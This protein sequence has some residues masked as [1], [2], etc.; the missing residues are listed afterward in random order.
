MIKLLAGAVTAALIAT[1]AF[2]VIAGDPAYTLTGYFIS[3]EGVVPGNDVVVD[4]AIVGKVTSVSLASPDSSSEGG[5]RIVM[6]IDKGAPLHQGT[7]AIIRPGGLLGN[8]FVQ[9]NPGP[10]GNS[11]IASGGTLP[12]Q[13]TSAPVDLDQVM[14]LFDRQTREQIR[15][16]TREGG[17]ALQDRGADLNA[18]LAALP[19]IT[20][21]TAAVTGK[22]AERDHELSALDVEFD[23]IAAMMAE[24]D[25]A[26]RRDL[27]NGAQI[28][29]TMAAHQA[30]LRDE[31]TYA[32]ATLAALEGGL[33]GHEHDL[34]QT[35][36]QMPALLRTLTSLSNH[37]ASALA[38]VGP[39][40]DDIRQLSAE[41]ASATSYR[42]ASGRMLLRVHPYLGSNAVSPA[43]SCAGGSR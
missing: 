35:L 9:L 27:G 16:L 6:R 30:Q 5:A 4:G 34:N 18:L 36:Q 3:A 11:A 26:F 31:L 33:K 37:S 38:I 25:R 42:D 8:M 41:M 29:D 21:D 23:R 32:A 10:A 2:H 40:V 7:K 13:D 43:A 14:D 15:T 28:L 12:M 22:I 24:E 20:Q 39:C 17:A 19:G 1:G